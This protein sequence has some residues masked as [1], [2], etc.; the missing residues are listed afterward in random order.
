MSG[1]LTPSSQAQRQRSEQSQS[2][3]SENEVGEYEIQMHYSYR[4]QWRAAVKDGF[5][6][7]NYNVDALRRERAKIMDDVAMGRRNLDD[8]Q[9]SRF[10]SQ[11]DYLE[12]K[13]IGFYSNNQKSGEGCTELRNDNLELVGWYIGRYENGMRHGIGQDVLI[14]RQKTERSVGKFDDADVIA[15][16][17]EEVMSYKIIP[18]IFNKGHIIKTYMGLQNEKVV[19]DILTHLEFF[20]FIGLIDQ[21]DEDL[22]AVNMPQNEDEQM[23]ELNRRLDL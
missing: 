18:R 11:F 6:I 19:D 21:Q 7:E 10:L 4:G 20:G 15:G 9:K 1:S 3:F 2:N 16:Q 5:G 17:P 8:Q 14:L 12:T 13:Y 23:N 22:E